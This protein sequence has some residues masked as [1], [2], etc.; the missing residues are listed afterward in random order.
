MWYVK[1]MLAAR[2]LLK[3]S[4]KDRHDYIKGERL[5]KERDFKLISLKMWAELV[6]M[7][8]IRGLKTT[9]GILSHSWSSDAMLMDVG[10]IHE[11]ADV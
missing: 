11:W 8:K 7:S 3:M 5:R 1:I 6:G 10:W 2:Y 4:G 9:S